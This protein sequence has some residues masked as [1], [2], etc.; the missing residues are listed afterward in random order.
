MNI[1]HRGLPH[2]SKSE[3]FGGLPDDF[4]E[5]AFSYSFRWIFHSDHHLVSRISDKHLETIQIQY[6]VL[7]TQNSKRIS[8]YGS[9]R[10]YTVLAAICCINCIVMEVYWL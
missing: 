10:H 8:N 9:K 7:F 2:S 6:E 5:L 1:G 3:V 4:L